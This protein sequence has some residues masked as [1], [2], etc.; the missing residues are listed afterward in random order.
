ML[1]ENKTHDAHI[2]TNTLLVVAEA[3]KD[4]V[5]V[6][7]ALMAIAA[8]RDVNGIYF[9]NNKDNIV[10]AASSNKILGNVF[11]F[12][13]KFINHAIQEVDF[14]TEE[15]WISLP[16]I[17]ENSYSPGDIPSDSTIVMRFS[18]YGYGKKFLTRIY[19]E[20]IVIVLVLIFASIVL[21]FFLHE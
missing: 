12:D 8:Q 9:V 21:Y 4:K 7:R 6:Q 5:S 17:I 2:L 20:I 1:L 3:M 19:K 10:F 14:D 15:F 16:V 11:P 18:I 13:P